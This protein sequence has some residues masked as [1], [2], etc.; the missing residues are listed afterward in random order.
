MT[1][2]QQFPADVWRKSSYSDSNQGECLEIADGYAD[3][4]I[5]DSKRPHGPALV[6]SAAAWSAFVQAVKG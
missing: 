4:P 3:V 2:A 6:F 1:P 5:R